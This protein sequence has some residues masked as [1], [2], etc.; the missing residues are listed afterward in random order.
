MATKTETPKIKLEA[1]P[2]TAKQRWNVSI[3]LLPWIIIVVSGTFIAGMQVGHYQTVN[4]Q[5]T[6]Q[7]AVSAQVQQLKA[8]E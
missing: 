1:K 7:D 6:V 4:D 2:L 8:S 3:N 5:K